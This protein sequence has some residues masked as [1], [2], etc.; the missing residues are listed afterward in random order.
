M[1]IGKTPFDEPLTLQNAVSAYINTV[2]KQAKLSTIG[3]LNS[4]IAPH[5]GSTLASD[6]TSK[7]AQMF[8]DKL[9]ENGLAV[10]TVQ[11]VFSL[12]RTS[13]YG[14]NGKVLEV[15][16]PKQHKKEVNFFTIEEQKRLETAAKESCDIDYLAIMLCLYTGIR[17]GELCGLQW[18]DIDLASGLLYVKRTVQR[19][20]NPGGDTKTQIAF[21]APKSVA[22]ERV[23]PLPDFLVTLLRGTKITSRNDYVIANGNNPIEPRTLQYRF[24]KI[25]VAAEVGNVNFHTTRHTFCVRALENGFDVKSLSEIMGHSSA[26]VTLNLYAHATDA[27]KRE[28]MNALSAVYSEL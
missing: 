4:Y 15:K 27:R 3:V 17:I 28:C 5:F 26:T 21:L 10:R 13:V 11:S 8:V 2:T 22:S 12:L 14:T 18:S 9:I 6:V 25:C 20:P 23:I 19:V 7:T 16:Y 24:K 1:I